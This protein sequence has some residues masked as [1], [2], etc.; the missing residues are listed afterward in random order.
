MG[1]AGAVVE[2][3][4]LEGE[5]NTL[6]VSVRVGWQ[7]RDRCG[8]CRRR[9]PGFDLGRG[10]RRWRAL[11]L[12][13]T[14]TW[15]EAESPRVSCPEH[16]V[17]VTWVP[18][19]RHGSRFTRAFE[20]Q[21]AWLTAHAAQNTVAALVRISWRSVAAIVTRVVGSQE[22]GRDLFAHLERIGIDEISYRKGQK[23]ITV[24]VDH[25]S[26]RLIWAAP[27]RDEATLHRFFDAVGEQ[28]SKRLRRVSRDGGSWIV[29]V[30]DQRCPQA[31][32][33]TD[34][35]HVVKW[36][37]DAL[38][39]VRR[40][41]WNQARHTGEVEVAQQLK[42][43]RWALW[44]NPENLTQRQ[45]ATL[46]E[47]ERTNQPL[48]RAYLL[49]EELRYVFQLSAR[50]GLPRA[51]RWIQWACRSRLAPFVKLA[52]TITEYRASIAAAL[53]YGLSNARVE[54][55]NQKICLIIRRSFG[56]HYPAA[57]IALAK[58]S[59][60]GLCPALPGRA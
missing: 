4:E 26:G 42:G 17:V 52:R 45:Q 15:L 13:S 39:E 24:V 9:A 33:C 41:V 19:A 5:T 44:H 10:R 36:A 29:N 27:G 49:K 12:G 59:L 11:D 6:V 55:G 3:V 28:R 38:D 53:R 46:V 47:I 60:G 7:D 23:Y 32:Q 30:L 57:L 54:S 58:L 25:D 56:F 35:F 34:P 51:A 22:G 1:L 8:I 37:T 21:A 40:A 18:W 16:G 20:D 48:F 14:V 43:A 31:I 2:R 50:R